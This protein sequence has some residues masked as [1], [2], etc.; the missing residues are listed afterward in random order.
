MCIDIVAIWFEITN[1]QISPI[2]SPSVMIMAGYY[3]FTFL[4][5]MRMLTLKSA[6]KTLSRQYSGFFY[7]CFYLLHLEKITLR[8]SYELSARPQGFH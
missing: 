3:L 7:Y 8:I 1:G 2:L 6:K 5:I 4:L